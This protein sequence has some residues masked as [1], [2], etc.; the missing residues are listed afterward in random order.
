M[1][2]LIKKQRDH[3][4]GLQDSALRWPILRHHEKY[5]W[6]IRLVGLLCC[7]H[8]D[9]RKHAL[10]SKET[11]VSYLV[12]YILQKFR[13]P[14]IYPRA[15]S[16]LSWC[17]NTNHQTQTGVIKMTVDLS[18]SFIK[19]FLSSVSSLLGTR[20]SSFPSWLSYL[21]KSSASESP[22][23][24]EDCHLFKFP[25]AVSWMTSG[26][27]KCKHSPARSICVGTMG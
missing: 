10:A 1:N 26:T 11:V 22:T 3:S 9:V 24:T 23:L 18:S 4:K 25:F 8:R 27:K 13:Y 16:V 14:N 12:F 5:T 7:Q 17:H 15:S 21:R 20:V 19:G 6:N 2:L